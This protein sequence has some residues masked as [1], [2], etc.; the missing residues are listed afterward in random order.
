MQ[1]RIYSALNESSNDF[2]NL[3]STAKKII[4]NDKNTEVYILPNPMGVKSMDIIIKK[5]NFL[6]GYDVKTISGKSSV[7]NR[8]SESIT[9]SYRV[10]LNLTINYNLRNLY[11]EIK[12]YFYANKEA[13]EVIIYKGKKE[14]KIDRNLMT[15]MEFRKLFR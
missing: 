7:Y 15:E 4:D 11:K 12:K 3:L 9:Q 2:D 13:I 5:R 8:L 10:I 6:G 14:I 1:N